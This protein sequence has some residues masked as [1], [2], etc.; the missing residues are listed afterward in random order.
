MAEIF[1]SDPILEQIIQEVLS[2]LDEMEPYQQKMHD[3]H[4][5]WKAR[6]T[7]GGKVRDPSTPYKFKLSLKRGKS[8]PPGAGG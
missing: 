2:L 8:A 4:P 3:K 6:L 1:F 7:R 5:R